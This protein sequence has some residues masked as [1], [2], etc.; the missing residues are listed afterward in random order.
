MNSL[1]TYYKSFGYKQCC[2][3]IGYLPQKE[4]QSILVIK[5]IRTSSYINNRMLIIKVYINPITVIRKTTL[6]K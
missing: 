4:A 3:N 5:Q 2:S 1:F 6:I